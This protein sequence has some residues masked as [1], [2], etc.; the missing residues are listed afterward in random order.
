MLGT[1]L[2]EW[3]KS[4]IYNI[5]DM[6]YFYN[7][8]YFIEFLVNNTHKLL[9]AGNSRKDGQGINAI[10]RQTQN[11]KLQQFK[12]LLDLV[13]IISI[14]HSKA[15]T[16]YVSLIAE[17]PGGKTEAISKQIQKYQTEVKLLLYHLLQSDTNFKG[18]FLKYASSCHFATVIYSKM[19]HLH[20]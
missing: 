20:H 6:T 8:N 3:K 2:L 14:M 13:I 10:K 4:I 17:S 18:L 19:C 15:L 5:I 9:L 7:L 11:P 12:F 16:I 1:K